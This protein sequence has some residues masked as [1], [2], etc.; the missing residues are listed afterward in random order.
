VW[1]NGNEIALTATEFRLLEFLMGRRGAVYT[2]GQ[3]AS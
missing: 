1:L 3:T 2:R